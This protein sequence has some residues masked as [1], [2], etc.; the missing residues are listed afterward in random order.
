M[1]ASAISGSGNSSP[2]P[3]IMTMALLVLATT[4]SRSLV[5]EFF[6]GRKGDELAVDA[7]QSDRPDRPLKGRLGQQQRRPMRR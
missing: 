7:G 3:S 2:K 6:H 4:R 1:M 5:L